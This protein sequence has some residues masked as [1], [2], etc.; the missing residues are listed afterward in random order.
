MGDVSG[1][2]GGVFYSLSIKTIHAPHRKFPSLPPHGHMFVS[3]T[4]NTVP[5][6]SGGLRWV[7][8]S[9]PLWVVGATVLRRW[10]LCSFISEQGEA[11][12]GPVWM[13]AISLA[14]C[15]E[16]VK[17]PQRHWPGAADSLTVPHV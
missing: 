7:R 4:T 15:P 8:G 10:N 17:G 1:R 14:P 3:F 5:A 11:C 16:A 2:V 9:E 12:L 13:A 6:I